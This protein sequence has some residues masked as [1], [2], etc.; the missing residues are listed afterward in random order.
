MASIDE[1]SSGLTYQASSEKIHHEGH[2]GYRG[3]APPDV[4]NGRGHPARAQRANGR[5]TRTGCLVFMGEGG[6]ML[7]RL[8][9]NRLDAAERRLGESLEYLR[10]MARASLGDFF[11]FAVLP[12]AGWT[13]ARLP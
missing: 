1:T 7:T 10:H 9:L 11:K 2:R 5:H 12:V 4:K 3:A 6:D 13:N 8:V